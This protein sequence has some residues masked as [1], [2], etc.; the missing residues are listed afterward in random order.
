MAFTPV[1]F[2]DGKVTTVKQV[3]STTIAKFDALVKDGNGLY[4]RATSGTTKVNYVALQ[5][6]VIGAITPP[7]ILVLPTHGVQFIADSAGNTAQ[8]DVGLT[9]SLTD[10]DTVNDDATSPGVFFVEEIVGVS[11]AKTFRGYF[12]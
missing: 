12:A 9:L 10:H 3:A 11:T 2:D 5:D 4:S 8:T 7:E 6:S 1:R